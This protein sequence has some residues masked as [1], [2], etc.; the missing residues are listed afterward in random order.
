MNAVL[1]LIHREFVAAAK[2]MQEIKKTANVLV[3][4]PCLR[5]FSLI[6]KYAL[7]HINLKYKYFIVKKIVETSIKLPSENFEE[8]LKN[9]LSPSFQQKRKSTIELVC[10]F[11]LFSNI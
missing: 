9:P 10:N 6:F 4:F 1:Q 3:S 7:I 8:D 11:P 5:K 2:V